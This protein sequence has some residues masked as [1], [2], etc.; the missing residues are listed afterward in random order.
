MTALKAASP[1]AKLALL[2]GVNH[3]LKQVDGDARAAN[4]AT[5]ADPE[6][7]LAAGVV[8]TIADFIVAPNRP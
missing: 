2:P 7:P 3:V 6:L 1:R 5:Y 4:L 8:P